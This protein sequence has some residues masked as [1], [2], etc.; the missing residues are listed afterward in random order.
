MDART[1]DLLRQ[2]IRHMEWADAEV[3]KAVL[4][5]EAARTDERL[6][7][8]LTHL[9]IVQRLF[10]ILWTKQPFD[11]GGKPPEFPSLSDLRAWATTY[12][13]EANRFLEG[14]DESRLSEEVFMPWV[15]TLETQVGRPLSMPTLGETIQQVSSHSTYHRGQVNARLRDVGGEPPLVDYIAWIWFGRPAPDWSAS[16][17]PA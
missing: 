4:A 17:D 14:L 7:N 1:I 9:H 16:A 12:Y 8:L 10:L 3:W 6:R 15:K 13:P 11:P 2:L 5:N